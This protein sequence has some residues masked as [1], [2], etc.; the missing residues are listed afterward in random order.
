MNLY[1]HTAR[2]L[3]RMLRE[4]ECS[5]REILQSVFDRID[6][7]DE[8]VGAYLTLDR[9][10]ALAAAGRVDEKIAAGEEPGPLAGIPVAVKD[11]ICTKGLLTTCASRMLYNFVPPYNATV[12]EKLETAGCVVPGKVNM[13]E[14]AMGSS[15]ETSYFKKTHNPHDLDR[16][17]GGS[18]GGSAAAVAAGEA[19]L[20]LGSDTGGSIRQPASCC[21]VIGLKPTYGRVSRYGLVAFAS[22]LDQIGPL[23]RDV[24]GCAAVYQEI[25]GH[26]PRDATSSPAPV[27]DCLQDLEKGAAGLRAALPREA[28][29]LAGPDARRC[30]L[31]AARAL[32]QLGARVEEISLPFWKDMLP[33]YY[34]LSSAEASSNLARYDGV[35]YGR[36]AQGAGSWQELMRRSR[37]EG[38]GREVK[39]RILLGTFVL[40]K[41]RFEA[42]Y[43][44]AQRVRQAAAAGLAGALGRCGLLL[45]PTSPEGPW[46]RG[47]SLPP[48]SA[49]QADLFTVPASMAGLPALSLPF[50]TDGEGLPVGVQLIGRAFEEKLLLQAAFALEEAGK[51]AGL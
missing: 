3:S 37:S 50:G 32:E 20:S 33:A 16:V 25:A 38:F 11:N 9:E 34:V 46:Q 10:G 22:S 28:L 29:E 13:D 44:R 14:F 43:A 30:T 12:M 41:E 47:R 45:T 31:E 17:P 4:K 15:C 2:E 7:C 49:Y 35:R 23:A 19:V 5:A 51:G 40:T 27:E 8:K 39:R 21:G 42:Y 48:A 6:A 1:Q 24:R 18:S 26:D 36:R